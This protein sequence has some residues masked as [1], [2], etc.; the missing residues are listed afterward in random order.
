[1]R[2]LSLAVLIAVI[3]TACSSSGGSST[4]APGDDASEVS[5]EE[6]AEESTVEPA[7][8]PGSGGDSDPLIAGGTPTFAPGGC[9]FNVLPGFNAEC[10]FVLV[11]E[12]RDDPCLLYTSD[13]ADE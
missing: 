7:A 8:I 9:Q 3:A 13:A 10:G 1:M 12:V 5:T 6:P 4:A 11:P 2:L